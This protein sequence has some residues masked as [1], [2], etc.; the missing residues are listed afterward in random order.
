VDELRKQVQKMAQE[1]GWE[2]KVVD[3]PGEIRTILGVVD[4]EDED[5]DLEGSEEIYKDEL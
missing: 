2:I 1:K 3:E 5:D 4:G